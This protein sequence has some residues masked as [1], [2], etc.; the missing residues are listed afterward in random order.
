M[1][2]ITRRLGFGHGELTRPEANFSNRLR[3]W[4]EKPSM[5]SQNIAC[6]CRSAAAAENRLGAIPARGTTEGGATAGTRDHG[7]GATAGTRTTI[8]GD[9]RHWG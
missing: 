1:E 5:T 6:I 4:C 9:G 8:G 2:P 7:R 3:C